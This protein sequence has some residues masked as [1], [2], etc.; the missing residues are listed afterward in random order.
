[1]KKQFMKFLNI[2][3]FILLI[4]LFIGCVDDSR[5]SCKTDISTQLYL[6][7]EHLDKNNLNV[8]SKVI[9]KVNVFVFDENLKLILKS[10]V[11]KESLKTFAGT[12]LHLNPGKYR[13]ICWANAMDNTFFQGLD[14]GANLASGLVNNSSS[15]N[16][17]AVDGDPLYY[18]SLDLDL[19]PKESIRK[20]VSF[21]RA[22]TQL[23]LFIQGFTDLNEE[24]INM[25]PL[26][27]VVNLPSG[28]DFDMLSTGSD[29]S[30]GNITS[31]KEVDGKKTALVKFNVA[32]LLGDTSAQVLIKKQSTRA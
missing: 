14:V 28:Y 16:K 24:G 20:T 25:P 5:S 27:E 26:V 13:V 30:L 1:M 23:E 4:G 22:H 17:Q 32:S 18:V 8:F 3:A 6:D 2:S 31:Y 11:S 7:F 15:G 12:S 9:E 21:C 19:S 10:D 29:L